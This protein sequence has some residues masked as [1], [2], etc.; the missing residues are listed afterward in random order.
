MERRRTF[1]EEDELPKRSLSLNSIP[2]KSLE[3]TFSIGIACASIGSSKQ[4]RGTKYCENEDRVCLKW[5]DLNVDGNATQKILF[6]GVFDGHGGRGKASTFV[7]DI[8]PKNFET[9]F[10]Q[11]DTLSFDV[12]ISQ[13]LESSFQL[14]DSEFH[15]TVKSEAMK[16]NI[17][18]KKTVNCCK[19][20]KEDP[21][22]CSDPP[23]S[24]NEGSTGTV[25]LVTKDSIFTANIGDS[26]A[27]LFSEESSSS[28][29]VEETD[30]NS[31]SPS[32]LS[33][34]SYENDIDKHFSP[35]KRLRNSVITHLAVNQ[36]T[37]T[38]TPIVDEENEDYRR[39]RNIAN[40]TVG[41]SA[42]DRLPLDG[43]LQSV[44]GHRFN[45]VALPGAR[46]LNMVR[47]FGN[48][49]N[50]NFINGK[51]IEIES[52]IIS[53]PHIKIMPRNSSMK[54]LIIASDGLWDNVEKD[55]I[56]SILLSH[57]GEHWKAPG[58]EGPK[59]SEISKTCAIEL[60][61]KAVRAK[62]KPDDVT[63]IVIP[64]FENII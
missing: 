14:T 36:I 4:F 48:L 31:S 6:A 33:T 13:A 20:F 3:Q 62:K 41:V 57:F 7:C 35:Y 21:C 15:N 32:S 39:I 10:N 9:L 55:E 59:I 1:R 2:F 60:M 54:T 19:Y 27:L 34:G 37:V 40:K 18:S 51:I 45:Y 25:V 52:P 53:R 56:T 58:S 63:V 22:S 30:S 50:K 47:A 8:L 49:G 61:R 44:R 64:L 12:R 11:L 26:D 42:S 17:G 38:D 28:S 16:L 24:A 23:I 46:S 29:L 43:I 5:L